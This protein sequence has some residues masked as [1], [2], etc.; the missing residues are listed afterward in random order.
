MKL[1]QSNSNSA[2]AMTAETCVLMAMVK[3]KMGDYN[4]ALALLEDSLIVLKASL[5][6]THLSVAKTMAQI[7]AVF[8]ELSN[9]DKA[10]SILLK[11]EEYQLA[12]VGEYHRDTFET[13]TLLGRLR[14]AVGDFD[15][16]LVQLHGVAEKQIQ[17]F[18][19]NHPSVSNQSALQ[20][21]F[22]LLLQSADFIILLR[23]DCRYQS[24]Y[25]RMLS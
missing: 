12:A 25:W 21:W 18:G 16:A 3:A 22:H 24:I 23:I 11:A 6:D 1:Q 9:Y 7:G 20:L 10:M 17:M 15:R 14:S 4:I 19:D 8:L 13:Q 2:K 5:G